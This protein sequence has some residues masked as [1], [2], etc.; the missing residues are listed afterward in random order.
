LILR[1]FHRRRLA[2]V[3]QLP[4]VEQDAVFPVGASLSITIPIS[5]L[6]MFF[7]TKQRAISIPIP[8]ASI[9]LNQSMGG[10]VDI[11]G[12]FF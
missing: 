8:L 5:Y 6:F 7:L 12:R 9:L 4:P 2:S 1:F 10:R 3:E 11:G